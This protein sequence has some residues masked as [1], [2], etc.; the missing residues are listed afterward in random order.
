[1]R[2]TSW[3]NLI[4]GATAVLIVAF[5]AVAMAY[6]AASVPSA[7]LGGPATNPTVY[8]N[9]TITFNPATGTFDYST[10]A[11]AVPTGATVVFTITN[12]DPSIAM[13]PNASDARVV[14]TVGGVMT[15]HANGQSAVVSSVAVGDIAH[16]FTISS[17]AYHLNVPIPPASASDAPTSV[18]FSV[19]FNVPGTYTWGCVVLCGPEST[20]TQ[21]KMYGSL[22]IS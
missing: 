10:N 18:T 5:G 17:G 4:A 12:Y 22:T 2:D 21:D 9:L 14:G 16:T 6:P 7:A 1:M 3:F 8:R 11:I 13:V 20:M 19:T 15:V